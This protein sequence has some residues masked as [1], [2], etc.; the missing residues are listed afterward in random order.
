MESTTEIL[1]KLSLYR[2]S[3]AYY[4]PEYACY[5]LES[6]AR[7]KG[8]R[9]IAHRVDREDITIIILDTK[10]VPDIV[11]HACCF[12]IAGNRPVQINALHTKSLEDTRTH[13]SGSAAPLPPPAFPS[14][15][16]IRLPPH[17]PSARLMNRC[18]RTN[19]ITYISRLYSIRPWV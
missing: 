16:P 17:N 11:L 19:S 9:G 3:A 6:C 12:F 5:S 7:R 13:I 14:H 2:D 8:G 18:E 4:F 1:V 10:L 15:Y